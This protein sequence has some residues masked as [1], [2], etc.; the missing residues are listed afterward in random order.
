MHS[1]LMQRLDEPDEPPGV[2]NTRKP[3]QDREAD[4]DEERPADALLEEHSQ[5]SL[6][7]SFGI[8]RA[9]CEA[10]GRGRTGGRKKATT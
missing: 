2:E 3:G 1:T 4:V 8:Q 6:G 7:V 5:L 9:L 10:K